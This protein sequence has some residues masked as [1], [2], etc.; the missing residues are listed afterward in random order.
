MHR[1][2]LAFAIPG[3]LPEKFGEHPVEFRSLR[4]TMTVPAMR[5]RDVVIG[6]QSLADADR[7]SFL[8]DVKMSE[9][10]HQSARIK[11]VR[12]LFEQPDH[13]HLPVHAEPLLRFGLR[14]LLGWIYCD[15]HFETPESLSSTLKMMAKSFSASPMALA[16][17]RTSF[18]IEVVGSGTFTCRPS[19][20]AS[21]TSFCIMF[22]LNH[23]S[24]GGLRTNGPRYWSIGDATTLCR[25]TSSAVSRG[26]P[27]FSASNTPSV[28]ARICV[29]RLR[30][31]AIF[32]TSA[33][34][35]SPTCVALGPSS[36]S[37]GLTRSNV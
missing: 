18:E 9:T 19:S 28:S 23:A 13:H 15:C 10:R 20:S 35:F 32:M 4:E 5:A 24:S 12:V 30:L 34:P 17:V 21:C 29:G 27:L 2:A 31:M 36:R 16:D 1:S 25:R 3:F 8:S 22:T 33:R 7:Y 14:E 6:I 26:I 37:S 11:I